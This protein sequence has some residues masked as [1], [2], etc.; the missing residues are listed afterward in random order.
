MS[1]QQAITSS[2]VAGVVSPNVRSTETVYFTKDQ[3]NAMIESSV[4]QSVT[5]LG[6]AIAT[7]GYGRIK[8]I[9]AAKLPPQVAGFLS[10]AVLVVTTTKLIEQIINYT[11]E[12]RLAEILHVLVDNSGS[13]GRIKVTVTTWEKLIVNPTMSYWTYYTTTSYEAVGY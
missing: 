12:N 5:G 9:L 13:F 6:W 11:D 4:G 2:N 3:I 7:Y 1:D 8:Q 10:L